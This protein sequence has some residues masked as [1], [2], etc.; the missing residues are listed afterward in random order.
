[1]HEAYAFLEP[2]CAVLR[3]RLAMENRF[4]DNLWLSVRPPLSL[5]AI[6]NREAAEIRL[7]REALELLSLVAIVDNEACKFL[8]LERC[9]LK[10]DDQFDEE[11][12]P[13]FIFRSDAEHLRYSALLPS[14][15]I[16]QFF[17]GHR[18]SAAFQA[19]RSTI[20]KLHRGRQKVKKWSKIPYTLQF[21]DLWNVGQSVL[22]AHWSTL[23]VTLD[24]IQKRNEGHKAVVDDGDYFV[25]EL[26]SMPDLTISELQ[27]SLEQELQ[28]GFFRPEQEMAV[29][30]RF[31]QLVGMSLL[32]LSIQ[33]GVSAAIDVQAILNACPR[34]D[35]LY[36]DSVQIDLD[37]LM[38]EVEKG[39][40]NIHSFGLTYYNAPVDVI[41]RFAK[42][43]GDP[44]SALT[45]GMRELCLSADNDE[46]PMSEESV[47]AFLDVLKT[48]GKLV[49]LELLVLPELFDRYAAA[50]GQHHRETL[51]IEKEKLPLRCRL[52]FLSVDRVNDIFFH[53]DSHVIQQIFDFA[54]INAKRTVRLR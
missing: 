45:N 22:S 50:F 44:S 25:Y 11:I 13:R 2:W 18:T 9:D 1:M 47:Q 31:L 33:T 39:T 54:A 6:L 52:A 4:S 5:L 20:L 51:S 29:V 42:K 35:Q 26:E 46:S 7:L 19:A 28:I 3:G 36:L 49:Y 12:I 23:L 16:R 37:V 30:L 40:A 27:V 24:E 53:L 38:L 8:L 14:A 32:K 17:L 34:L 15:T 41:T 21:T 43:L 48:N 10:L